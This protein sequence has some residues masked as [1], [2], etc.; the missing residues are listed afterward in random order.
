MLRAL[1]PEL[2]RPFGVGFWRRL[3]AGTRT[4]PGDGPSRSAPCV[5]G[6]AKRRSQRGRSASTQLSLRLLLSLGHVLQPC[7]YSRKR[8]GHQRAGQSCACQRTM[9]MPSGRPTAANLASQLA[10]LPCLLGRV[11]SHTVL[12]RIRG[13]HPAE[14][15]LKQ[16][17]WVWPKVCTG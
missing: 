10:T 12:L 16:G 2:R 9:W 5:F 11:I 3:C 14:S 7:R 13:L 1:A 17:T 15:Y 8:Q 4:G 6:R